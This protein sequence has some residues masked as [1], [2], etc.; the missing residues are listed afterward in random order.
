M[1]ITLQTRIYFIVTQIDLME[2]KRN[3]LLKYQQNTYIIKTIKIH[4]FTVGNKIHHIP[5]KLHII[6]RNQKYYH[7]IVDFTHSTNS[8]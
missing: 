5:R 7:K 4:L 1:Y 8:H 3:T 2:D 6:N